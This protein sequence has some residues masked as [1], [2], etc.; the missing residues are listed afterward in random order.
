MKREV[1]LFCLGGIL[2]ISLF[3]GCIL[4]GA[5]AIPPSEVFAILAG[6]SPQE[7]YL[8]VIVLQSRLPMAV[9][10][11]CC[12]ACLSVAGL[13]MQTLFQNPLA[14]PSV[15]GI[16]SGAS[17]GVAVIML[18]SGALAFG[19][20]A[21][22]PLLA[23]VGALVGA[24]AVMLLL[25]LF[26]SVLRSAVS[27]L[28]VGVMIGYVCSS[29]ISLLNYFSPAEGVRSYL[30]WGLG[31]FTA[32]RLSQSLWL[33][34]LGM[35]VLLPSMLLVKP[36]DALLLGE[37]YLSSVGYGV[38]SVRG[39]VLVATGLLVGIPTA[40]CGPIGFLGLVVPHLCRLL[41]R[42]S[43]HG[44]LLP[45]SMLFGAVVGLLCALLCVIPSASFGVLPINVI[46]PFIGVPVI[47]YLLV[48][49]HRLPYFS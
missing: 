47:L 34:V 26:S 28:I 40:F 7:S 3:F 5:V 45:A 43:A 31:S 15:L 20:S 44:L 35:A 10:A 33:A 48:C 39:V 8:S 24:G 17:L 36:L 9:T 32:L 23:V 13:L 22:Q 41:F 37:S 30:V 18:A 14:G 6:S 38:R 2:L 25:F 16:S 12:G 27:L 49:R 42:S 11:A 19:G 46:T 1:W 4:V 29:G 21:F